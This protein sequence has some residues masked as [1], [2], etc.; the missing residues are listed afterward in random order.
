MGAGSNGSEGVPHETDDGVE[1]PTGVG[2][3]GKRGWDAG[4]EGVGRAIEGGDGA[5]LDV[6]VGECLV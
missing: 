6:E 5:G 2:E 1:G 4:W 3:R